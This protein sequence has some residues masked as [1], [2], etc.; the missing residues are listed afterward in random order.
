MKKKVIN[1]EYAPKAIGP[2]SQAIVLGEFV[3]TSGQL[4]IN[5][6]AGDTI[7][8]DIEGQTMQVLKNLA[9]ILKSADCNLS[10]VVKTTVFLSDM[11]NFAKMNEVYAQFFT[12]DALPARTTVQV[13]RLPKDVLVEIEAIA[14]K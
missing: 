11:N 13:S 7:V 5:S 1:T 10:Q 4:P 12:G 9:E 6:E 14:H 8:S 2:Y 3:F